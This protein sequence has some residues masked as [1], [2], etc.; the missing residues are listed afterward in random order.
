MDKYKETFETWNKLAAL[1]QEKFMHLDLYDETYEWICRTLDKPHAT[2][3]EIGCGPGNITKYLLT[4]RPDFDILGIDVAP[5]MIALAKANNPTA[6]FVAMDCRNIDALTS[7]YDGIVCG[8]CLP[9]LSQAD[10]AKLMTDCAELLHENGF[11]YLSFVE[12]DPQESGYQVGS[13]GD[14][15]YFYH[16][17]LNEL[18]RL[19]HQNGF[20]ITKH[21][22]VAYR[23][24]ESLIE[25]HTILTARK[26]THA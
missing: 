20:E 25:Y 6:R 18:S 15:T 23:R 3:L 26:K 14:R 19:L 1:Y 2:I 9:Y 21:F 7:R 4:K 11:L 8:F 5:N 24:N 22:K 10:S 12:G 13:S 16:H 17:S